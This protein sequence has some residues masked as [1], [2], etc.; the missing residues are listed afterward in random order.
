MRYRPWAIRG[1]AAARRDR[2]RGHRILL[3]TRTRQSGTPC[4]PPASRDKCR[5]LPP[6]LWS[7][8]CPA[9]SSATF[10]APPPPPPPRGGGGDTKNTHLNTHHP[11]NSHS[12]FFF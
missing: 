6:A 5:S 3:P 8:S 4:R 12:L 1:A 11:Q 10:H 2:C 7:R 9:H